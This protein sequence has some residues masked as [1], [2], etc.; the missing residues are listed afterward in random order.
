MI[1]FPQSQELKESTMKIKDYLL[2]KEFSLRYIKKAS[3]DRRLFV[4]DRSVYMDHLLQV[5]D[6]LR[7]EEP[8]SE[9]LLFDAEEMDLCILFE[10]EDILILDKPPFLLVHPT[11]NHPCHTLANGITDHFQKQQL[12][13]PVRFV[14]R[15]DRDTSGLILIAKSS[16]AHSR[17]SKSMDEGLIEKRYLALVEGELDP[18]NGSINLP[19]GQ[20]PNSPL[21]RCVIEGGQ[22]SITHYRTLTKYSATSILPSF[23]LIEVQLGTGRTHQIRV[24]LAHLG[25]PLLGDSLYASNHHNV[26]Q[27]QALHAYSL[28]FPHPRSG[29]LLHIEIDL[30]KD[31]RSFLD[32]P[33]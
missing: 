31:L 2:M 30:A 13:Q 21:K 8:M 1:Y 18:P 27:R 23:S 7:I 26:L 17:L 28:S 29:E 16:L 5:G 20:D 22:E 11:K 32:Q 19:I 10:D 33:Q 12:L 14:S 3:K 25:H 24:H 9:T 6:T 4:N 15:L